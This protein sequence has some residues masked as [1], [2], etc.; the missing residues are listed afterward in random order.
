MLKNKVTNL[1]Q[2]LAAAQQDRDVMDQNDVLIKENLFLSEENATLKNKIT[3]LEHRLIGA[4]RDDGLRQENILLSDE[5]A[6]HKR[7]NEQLEDLLKTAQENLTQ[8]TNGLNWY[9]DHNPRG[10][11]SAEG[12]CD[13]VWTVFPFWRMP[14]SPRS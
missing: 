4:Q 1:Q 5:C 10:T 3:N 12:E 9:R 7:V 14:S 2:R 6:T 8:K 13:K 11:E